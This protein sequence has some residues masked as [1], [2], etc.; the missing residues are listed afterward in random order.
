MLKE[1]NLIDLGKFI[2][3]IGIVA[4]HIPPLLN[5]SSLSKVLSFGVSLCVPFFFA[6]SSFLFFTR[7]KSLSCSAKWRNL[8]KFVKRIVVLYVA[9]MF[10]QIILKPIFPWKMFDS[11]FFC[12]IVFGT[13]YPGSWFYSALIIST[14]II[15]ALHKYKIV[16]IL[17]PFVVYC[18]FAVSQS[19]T[20]EPINTLYN[21]YN[22]NLDMMFLSFPY[23][24]IWTAIGWIMTLENKTKYVFFLSLLFVAFAAIPV[25]FNTKPLLTKG[26]ESWILRLF[27]CF[28]YYILYARKQSR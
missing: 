7:I 19:G 11:G 13:T 20:I 26:I 18:Y 21:W 8:G 2:S 14:F 24:L 16:T 23:A 3:S 22:R 27:L 1:Y 15:F 10:I 28:F 12:K 17:I 25:F 9:W 4:L 6:V 5:L